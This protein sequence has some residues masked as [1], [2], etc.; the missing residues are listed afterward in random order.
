MV[1]QSK[2][3][4]ATFAWLLP[5]DLHYESFVSLPASMEASDLRNAPEKPPLLDLGK[6]LGWTDI[7]TNG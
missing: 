6:S 5:P 1:I 7:V 4:S 2:D 3:I